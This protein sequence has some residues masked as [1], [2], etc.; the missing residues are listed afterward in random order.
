MV[1]KNRYYGMA[2]SINIH[3]I[4][5]LGRGYSCTANVDGKELKFGLLEASIMCTEANS[6]SV[7]KDVFLSLR[8]NEV[9]TSSANILYKRIEGDISSGKAKIMEAV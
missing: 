3:S 6:Y 2:K 5:R 9:K 7:A 1:I 4:E 8:A